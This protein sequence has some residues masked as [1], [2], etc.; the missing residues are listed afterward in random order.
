MTPK[1]FRVK[2]QRRSNKFC[3]IEEKIVVL[4][5][6][7]NDNYKSWVSFEYKYICIVVYTIFSQNSTQRSNKRFN[8]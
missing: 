8:R 6:Q 1:V 7:N 5:W 4:K 3:V 2:N